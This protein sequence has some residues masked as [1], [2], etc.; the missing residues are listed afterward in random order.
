MLR[1]A[2]GTGGGVREKFAFTLP[3]DRHKERRNLKSAGLTEGTSKQLFEQKEAKAAEGMRRL[4][5]GTG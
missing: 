3:D 2:L 4:A 1:L 5:L